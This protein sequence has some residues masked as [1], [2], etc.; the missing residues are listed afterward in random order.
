MPIQ[1]E[2]IIDVSELDFDSETSQTTSDWIGMF[3]GPNVCA[4]RFSYVGVRHFTSHSFVS[5]K[6]S[7]F[8]GSAHPVLPLNF[9]SLL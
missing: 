3:K 4:Q 1:L 6:I 2:A 9:N 7:G 8:Q 5:E